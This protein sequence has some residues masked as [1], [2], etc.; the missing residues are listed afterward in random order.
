MPWGDCVDCIERGNKTMV[1]LRALRSGLLGK[2]K[3]LKGVGFL[4]YSPNGNPYAGE[5]ASMEEYKP[6]K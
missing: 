6:P 1:L 4:R 3:L 2:F 5:R